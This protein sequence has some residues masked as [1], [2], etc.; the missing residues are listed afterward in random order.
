[1]HILN[2]NCTSATCTKWISVHRDKTN[3]TADT[4]K[5]MLSYCTLKT[6]HTIRT[7]HTISTMQPWPARNSLCGPGWPW[8]RRSACLCSQSVGIKSVCTTPGFDHTLKDRHKINSSWFLLNFAYVNP[9]LISLISVYSS[10]TEQ[11]CAPLT[12]QRAAPT[13]SA[14][15]VSSTVV[16]I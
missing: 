2:T 12:A 16:S 8:N 6:P 1:M 11:N 4:L 14:V 7:P 3:V 9:D 15:T 13:M 10:C 5:W